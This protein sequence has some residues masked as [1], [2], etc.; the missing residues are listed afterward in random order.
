[1]L[2]VLI[3]VVLLL[4]LDK[5]MLIYEKIIDQYEKFI[6]YIYIY[7][8]IYYKNKYIDFDS[9]YPI[10]ISNIDID[11]III[12]NKAFFGKKAFKY[13]TG[14]NDEENVKSLCILLPKI[15]HKENVLI[16]LNTCYF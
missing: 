16:K 14:Y 12:F 11:K 13:F 7:I 9:K 10:I 2:I 3:I 5:N 4:K 1:M 15:V 8:Y 6:V